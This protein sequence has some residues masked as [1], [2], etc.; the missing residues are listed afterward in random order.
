MLLVK[1]YTFVMFMLRKKNTANPSHPDSYREGK[2]GVYVLG[3][4]YFQIINLSNF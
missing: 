3:K 4:Y 1:G 2:R